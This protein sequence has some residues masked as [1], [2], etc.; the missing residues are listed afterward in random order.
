MIEATDPFQLPSYF[1]DFEVLV[2]RASLALWHSGRRARADITDVTSTTGV[3]SVSGQPGG[4]NTEV[5]PVREEEPVLHEAFAD[6]AHSESRPPSVPPDPDPDDADDWLDDGSFGIAR[7]ISDVWVPRGNDEEDT[8]PPPRPSVVIESKKATFDLEG[9]QVVLIHRIS[10]DEVRA[11]DPRRTDLYF[12]L[13]EI[14]GQ[15]LVVLTLVASSRERESRVLHWFLDVTKETHLEVAE[16]LQAAYRA[17]VRLYTPELSEAARF[18][19]EGE[20]E[21][22]VAAVLDRARMLLERSDRTYDFDVI[23][24]GFARIKQPLGL[25][26]EGLPDERRAR[27]KS[28]DEALEALEEVARYRDS[29]VRD[30]LVFRRSFPIIRLERLIDRAIEDAIR[31]GVELDE[32]FRERALRKGLTGAE[33]LEGDPPGDYDMADDLIERFGMAG[34]GGDHPEED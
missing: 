25:G 3:T 13:H 5:D 17:E 7:P 34:D 1:G 21:E 10:A 27:P 12:Q 18:E 16:Q 14:D 11:F 29:G 26:L 32:G 31:F 8:S 23:T 19:V 2:G 30:D 28:H 6:L 15:P 22:N 24:A 9:D 4:E 33:R 20:R